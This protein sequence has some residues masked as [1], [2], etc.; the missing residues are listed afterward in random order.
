MDQAIPD[1]LPQLHGFLA[2]APLE[3]RL[4]SCSSSPCWMDSHAPRHCSSCPSHMATW[5]SITN[6]I[7]PL[8]VYL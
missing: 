3:D 6:E 7:N 4:V 1:T 8:E 2:G 5:P